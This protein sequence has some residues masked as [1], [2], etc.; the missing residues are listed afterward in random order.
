MWMHERDIAAVASDNPAV[1][2]IEFSSPQTQIYGVYFPF[3]IL[4]LRDMGMMLGELWDF[5]NLAKDC[6]EDGV[7]EFLLAAPPLNIS[8][9]LGSPVNPVAIK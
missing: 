6:A 8:G 7:Y 4:C 9:A 3:H 1:E 5:D 2:V